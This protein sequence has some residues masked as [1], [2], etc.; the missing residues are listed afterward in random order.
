MNEQKNKVSFFHSIKVKILLL[1]FGTVF[2]SVVICIAT[3]VPLARGSVTSLTENYM[4]DLAYI[5]GSSL[6]RDVEI[7]VYDA[8]ITT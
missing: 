3:A 5:A 4:E 1:V 6:E 7:Q 8:V 2:S